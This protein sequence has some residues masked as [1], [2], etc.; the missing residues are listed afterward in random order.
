ME[1][2]L[3]IKPQIMQI[4]QIKDE[5]YL[6]YI[7]RKIGR[8][9]SSIEL[10]NPHTRI[11]QNTL[12]TSCCFSWPNKQVR[13]VN[14]WFEKILRVSL[15]NILQRLYT[16]HKTPCEKVRQCHSNASFSK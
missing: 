3:D 9:S 8:N 15:D 7:K 11:I 6:L 16:K 14:L 12:R 5:I 4:Q 1:R 10:N 13:T 2:I